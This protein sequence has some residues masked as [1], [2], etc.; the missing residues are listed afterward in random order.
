MEVH[1]YERRTEMVT[2]QHKWQ[3]VTMDLDALSDRMGS[4]DSSL[5]A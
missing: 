4:T 5:V 3:K 2:S 1:A